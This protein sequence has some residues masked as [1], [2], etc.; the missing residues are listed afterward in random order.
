MASIIASLSDN[1]I[2]PTQATLS[3][4]KAQN[5]RGSRRAALVLCWCVLYG[6]EDIRDAEPSDYLRMAAFPKETEDIGP[7]RPEALAME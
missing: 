4:A 3:L 7:I 6:V 5:G 2:V 1:A